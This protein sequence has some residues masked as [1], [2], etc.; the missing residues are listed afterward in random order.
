M[1]E[2]RSDL[3]TARKESAIEMKVDL[4]SILAKHEDINEVNLI[5]NVNR[6]TQQAI[7]QYGSS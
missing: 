7:Q 4:N 3:F 6:R 2:T 5:N 1:S